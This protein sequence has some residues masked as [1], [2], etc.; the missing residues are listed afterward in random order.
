MGQCNC[1]VLAE[2][3]RVGGIVG[4][5]SSGGSDGGGGVDDNDG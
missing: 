3:L 5:G 4:G 1:E 2:N